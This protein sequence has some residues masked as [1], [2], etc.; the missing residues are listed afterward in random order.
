MFRHAVVLGAAL[1][2]VLVGCSSDED[3]HRNSP[4]LQQW[5]SEQA[6]MLKSAPAMAAGILAGTSLDPYLNPETFRRIVLVLLVV[7]GFRLIFA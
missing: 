7:M 3:E 2:T 5:K 1:A 6:D 4:W